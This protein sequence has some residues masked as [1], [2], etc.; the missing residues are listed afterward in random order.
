L[1]TADLFKKKQPDSEGKATLMKRT[2]LIAIFAVP[3]A[4]FRL[5]Q[6]PVPVKVEG[7]LM[8]G[9]VE[10]GLTIYRGIAFAAPLS[11]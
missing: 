3:S 6:A 7:G 9:S 2:L 4:G 10:D 8:Q 11:R 1:C 5:A